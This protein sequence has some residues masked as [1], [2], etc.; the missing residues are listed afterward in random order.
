VKSEVEPETHE[1]RPHYNEG[2]S[3]S[4]EQSFIDVDSSSSVSEDEAPNSDKLHELY[5][6]PTGQKF[7]R[8]YSTQ[9]GTFAAKYVLLHLK[10]DLSNELDKL[11]GIRTDGKRWLLGNTNVEIADDNIYVKG[12]EYKGTPGL[13][14]LLFL[15][16]PGKSLITT[17]DLEI[18]KQLLL[19]TSAHKQSY[20]PERQINSNKGVKYVSVIKPLF[21]KTAEGMPLQSVKYER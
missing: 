3:T 17:K 8:D 21:T 18:Y 20:D 6:T 5:S 10:K 2:A 19:A 13:F 16:S 14:E 11:Y 4:Q 9:F 1:E 7:A 15:T 12:K